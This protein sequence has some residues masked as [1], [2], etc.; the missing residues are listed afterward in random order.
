M[1][2]MVTDEHTIINCIP[3]APPHTLSSVP[4]N[5]RPEIVGE[6]FFSSFLKPYKD[7]DNR[8]PI[9]LNTVEPMEPEA[10]KALRA[11]GWNILCVGPLLHSMY[12]MR[13]TSLCS[14]LKDRLGSHECLSWL[15]LKAEGSVL[16]VCFGT[17]F[18]LQKKEFEE[19]AL[20]IEESNLSFLWSLHSDHVPGDCRSFLEGFIQRTKLRGLVLPWVPQLDV[21]SH[22]SVGG[23][24]S[25]CGWNSTLESIYCGVPMIGR[26]VGADQ[27]LNLLCLCETWKMCLRLDGEIDK[28]KVKNT[29]TDLFARNE[30]KDSADRLRDVIGEWCEKGYNTVSFEVLVRLIKDSESP[31]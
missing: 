24:L 15:D 13:S 6:I 31:K 12:S 4:T 29:I 28:E 20:G 21:L 16:Y 7:V 27:P 25:H 14:P 19:V 2:A 11:Q 9:F 30:L 3:G 1:V 22:R 5:L 18:H 8:V 26:P 17:L 23:F 10:L